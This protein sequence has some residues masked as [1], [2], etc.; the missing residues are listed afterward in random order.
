MR[1]PSVGSSSRRSGYLRSSDLLDGG[2]TVGSEF[3]VGGA[4][5]PLFLS[6][7][8]REDQS[9][10]SSELVEVTLEIDDDSVV[11]CSV[12]PTSAPENQPEG[13]GFFSR[14][15]SVTSRI[16][17]KFPWLRSA[18]GRSSASG[19]EEPAAAVSFAAR[20]A[21]KMQAQLD[22]TRSSAQRALT[23]LRFISKT[24]SESAESSELWKRVEDR[25][26]SLAKDGFLSR[27]DFAE[28]IGN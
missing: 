8:H 28:C 14:S 12:A 4:M 9:S 6:D 11:V 20:D 3:A 2:D 25:F 7:L 23:G 17:R 15:S 5:L 21:R 10:S 27:D 13:N 26:D 16:R 24:T 19:A 22:R 18:S 1:T